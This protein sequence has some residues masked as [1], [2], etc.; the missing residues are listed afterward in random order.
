M[1]NRVDWHVGQAKC[2]GV[3]VSGNMEEIC[4]K[5]DNGENLRFQGRLFSECSYFDEDSGCMTRQQL[6]VTEN[7]DQIYYIVR[8]CGQERS[9]RVYRL[10]VREDN[11]VINNGKSEIILQFDMLMLAVRA[12]CG[13]NAED[14]PSLESV[15]ELLKAAN[16]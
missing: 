12:L 9:R 13:L 1:G 14:T 10:A 8:S 6:Y 11:C 7:R 3:P 5:D 4:L 16:A 2:R 15:E